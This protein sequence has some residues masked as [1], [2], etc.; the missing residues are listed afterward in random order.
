MSPERLMFARY[1]IKISRVLLTHRGV[2]RET[3]LGSD[4]PKAPDGG[5]SPSNH[6]QP[7]NTSWDDSSRRSSS[8]G[9]AVVTWKVSKL[10]SKV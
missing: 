10:G 7:G 1:V 8:T 6:S 3:K 9:G 4:R 2:F 5:E